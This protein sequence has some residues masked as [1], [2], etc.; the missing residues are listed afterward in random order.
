MK[1]DSPYVAQMLE[2]AAKIRRYVGGMTYEE[3]L[4]DEKT[5]SAVLM[6]LQQIGEMA[7]R[8]SEK[9]KTEVDVPW[10]KI[11]GFRDVVAH[12]YIDIDLENAWK[13]LSLDLTQTESA[14]V[15]YL[16]QHPLPEAKN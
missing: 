15:A 12:D 14:L 13:I 4:K 10:K 9:T 8:V 1:S 3:F 11:A 7:K 2:C 6:Q 5:Q 16:A